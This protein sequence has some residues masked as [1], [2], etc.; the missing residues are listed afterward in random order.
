MDQASYS[1]TH[2]FM[3]ILYIGSGFVGSCSA[4]VSA[5][6]G[7]DVLVY[8]IDKNKIMKLSNLILIHHF[9]CFAKNEYNLSI[10]F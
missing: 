5:D 4:A 10:R 1:F 8:D 2:L 7:H 3:N 9:D 6:S